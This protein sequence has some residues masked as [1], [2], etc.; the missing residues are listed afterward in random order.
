VATETILVIE[1]SLDDCHPQ[2]IGYVLERA[3]QLGALDAYTV[4]AQMKKS[5]PGVVL[6]L[7]ARPEQR[8]ALVGLLLR[9]TSTLG[10]R[11]M[12]CERETVERRIV[13]VSTRYGTIRVKAAGDKA[14]PEYEDCRA[15]AQRHGVPLRE[16][17]AAALAAY[18]PAGAP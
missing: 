3:L 4:A 15:A 18:A 17:M 9:E 2:V 5:R 6:T 7:L 10:V 8:D 11:I 16:V 1:T 14:A 13:S 12:A